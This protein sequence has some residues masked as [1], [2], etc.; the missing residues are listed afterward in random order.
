M[1]FTA[2]L[3]RMR[4]KVTKYIGLDE[5]LR[6]KETGKL[7]GESMEILA[8]V[9]SLRIARRL[10]DEIASKSE[11]TASGHGEFSVIYSKSHDNIVE[12]LII[13]KRAFRQWLLVKIV[14]SKD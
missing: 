5:I 3:I 7:G 14:K 2:T 8:T 13:E 10:Q 4:P 12:E 11:M 9:Q 1:L 6:D